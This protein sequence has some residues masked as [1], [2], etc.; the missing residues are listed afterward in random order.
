MIKQSLSR[1][2]LEM[3]LYFSSNTKEKLKI[4]KKLKA[5]N[6]TKQKIEEKESTYDYS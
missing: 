2:I 3:V 6:Y 4:L 1:E 5:A